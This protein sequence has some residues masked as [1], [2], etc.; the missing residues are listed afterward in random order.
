[1]IPD[2]QV[3][4]MLKLSHI[5]KHYSDKDALADVSLELPERGLVVVCG[6]SG[7][8]KSTLLNIA[9]GADL[10]SEGN[11]EFRGEQITQK[12]LDAYRNRYVSNIYQD[13]MLIP[14][15]TVR[16]N[17]SLA[18]YAEKQDC[19]QEMLAALLEQ[20]GLNVD[21]L[22]KKVSHLSGGEKQRVAVARAL[23]KQDA[24]LFADEPTGNLD[25]KN[26]E[27][28]MSLLQTIAQDRLVI[29]VS[30][31]ERLNQKYGMYFVELEDGEVIRNT[32][33]QA[34][35]PEK[36]AYVVE[37][38][39]SIDTAQKQKQAR[40]PFRALVRR[41][42]AGYEKNK[43]KSV[44]ASIGFV[45]VCA[46]F[47]FATC[48]FVED[49]NLALASSLRIAPQ[50]NVL[51]RFQ[52]DDE[53]SIE[54]KQMMCAQADPPVSRAYEANFNYSGFGVVPLR[55]ML[56]YAP[57]KPVDVAIVCGAY[58]SSVGEIMLPLT[59]AENMIRQSDFYGC[60]TVNEL[61]GKPYYMFEQLVNDMGK[62]SFV[63]A[64]FTICGVFDDGVADREKL[65]QLVASTE[66]GTYWQVEDFYKANFMMKSAISYVGIGE[67][68]ALYD[69]KFIIGVQHYICAA[70]DTF[71][72][73]AGYDSYA[74]YAK[75]LEPLQGNEVY[76]T[77]SAA[78]D[79]G[80]SAGDSLDLEYGTIKWVG[81]IVPKLDTEGELRG[82]QVKG[83]VS[84]QITNETG[85]QILFAPE[86]YTALEMPD[87]TVWDT[88]LLYC[89]AAAVATP[90]VWANHLARDLG[91]ILDE[92]PRVVLR[93]RMLTQN[94]LSIT[95]F[96]ERMEE[97]HLIA[98]LPLFLVGG[99][100][101]FSIAFAFFG[102]LLSSKDHLYATL[103]A[104]GF[105]RKRM[106]GI[107]AAQLSVIWAIGMAFGLALGAVVCD[108]FNRFLYPSVL[109]RE[110]I[111]PLGWHACLIAVGVTLVSAMLAIAV[112]CRKVFA[113][114]IAK[115]KTQ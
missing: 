18:S 109:L 32:L 14:E 25:R 19:T 100:C 26:G 10:P 90:Y 83:I 31:N 39:D 89:N 15:F 96:Y 51:L 79:L 98:M 67:R 95:G 5:Y 105:D 30:H 86:Q 28:V 60:A 2:R 112:K 49:V 59:Y 47:L 88:N 114:T 103:R 4:N 17:I 1:M 54:D 85:G 13:F 43:G 9:S 75:T 58:P 62:K 99:L 93:W 111:V 97:A 84:D 71:L 73:T 7:S 48:C 44:F 52:S 106:F 65:A 23:I 77:E 46:V 113:G 74:P 27:T 3:G 63:R 22:D 80:K 55:T 20:V 70:A 42:A 61:V 76:L 107:M 36:V 21:Y 82:L 68:L 78:Q 91:K 94:T 38:T 8:G 57:E 72:S 11:V 12:N 104:I 50:K 92:D 102:F 66:S 35:S 53:I 33:P 108:L 6:E 45:I 41:T 40:M 37:K 87:H 110:I 24:I 16:E 29:V 101:L 69:S 34:Q 115:V 56:E 64:S 81:G